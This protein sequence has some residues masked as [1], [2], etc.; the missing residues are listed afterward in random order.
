MRR[1]ILLLLLAPILTWSCTRA[2]ASS[3]LAYLKGGRLWVTAIEATGKPN[4]GARPLRVCR[5]WSGETRLVWSPDGKSLAIEHSDG[6]YSG[7]S[8]LEAKPN[9]APRKVAM[10]A[11]PSFSPGGA[12]LAFMRI[13]GGDTSVSDDK[14]DAC[15]IELATAN[16]RVL[17]RQA[18]EPFW[19]S[20]G[21]MI[22]LV[23]T[24]TSDFSAPVLVVDAQSGKVS[25][26]TESLVNPIHPFLSP[27]GRY[28]AFEPHTSRPL[29]G[30]VIVDLRTGRFLRRDFCRRGYAQGPLQGFSSDERWLLW[31]WRVPDPNND[32]SWLREELWLVSLDAK[33]K[34]RTG[35]GMGEPWPTGVFAPD[36]RHILWLQ[37]SVKRHRDQQPPDLLWASVSDDENVILVHGV[38]AFA[39]TSGRTG[40]SVHPA[41]MATVRPSR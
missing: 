25:F 31:T 13:P 12:H 4:A 28:L 17:R 1:Q 8:L 26:Q 3:R 22:A 35:R 18:K 16:T 39:I 29:S 20:D 27:S 9:S 36:G 6:R 30:S 34:H 19:S 21:T 7:I 10:G 2:D 41:S 37:P 14:L 23:S 15:V 32:G 24:L 38:S 5:A 33:A 40:T 11:D